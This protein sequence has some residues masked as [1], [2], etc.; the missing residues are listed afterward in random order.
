MKTEDVSMKH[1]FDVNELA[2]MGKE[3]AGSLDKVQTLKL[4]FDSV[5]KQFASS[6]AEGEA[7]VSRISSK[8]HA[9][10]EMRT[11]KCYLLDE[12]PEGYRL[13]IR[14]DNG[15]VARRRKLASEERQLVI[16]DKVPEPYVAAVILHV[17]DEGWDVDAYEV[18]LVETE[19]NIIRSLDVIAI[20]D[21]VPLKAIGE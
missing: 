13:V 4:E 10:W 19:F 5:K 9:G 7:A 2:N 18:P 16:T 20:R 21:Y 6:I 12:R 11:I 8:V 15:H 14:S 17:D 3:Q 1:Q